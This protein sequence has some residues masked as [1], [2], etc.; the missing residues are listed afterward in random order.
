MRTAFIESSETGCAPGFECKKVKL[1]VAN[2]SEISPIPPSPSSTPF[3]TTG[4]LSKLIPRRLCDTRSYLRDVIACDAR[5]LLSTLLTELQEGLVVK[6]LLPTEPTTPAPPT[7]I[8]ASRRNSKTDNCAPLLTVTP[9]QDC[10]QESRPLLQRFKKLFSFGDGHLPS[11]SPSKSPDTVIRGNDDFFSPSRSSSCNYLAYIESEKLNHDTNQ[12]YPPNIIIM[13][14]TAAYDDESQASGSLQPISPICS[15]EDVTSVQLL[16]IRLHLDSH[17]FSETVSHRR[18]II[19]HYTVAVTIDYAIKVQ[20]GDYNKQKNP[21]TESPTG[22]TGGDSYTF[23]SARIISP[24]HQSK[25][26]DELGSKLPPTDKQLTAAIALSSSERMV[27][28]CTYEIE[29]QLD[30][31]FLLTELMTVVS[32]KLRGMSTELIRSS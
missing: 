31:E 9:Q 12:A 30:Y 2:N 22:S 20:G 7:S 21:C 26:E 23:G 27:Q 8:T 15:C 28:S 29:I 1:I 4:N 17:T 5:T 32:N 10:W 24:P 11:E 25:M 19:E 18:D 13:S 3:N 6:L 14:R 16:L